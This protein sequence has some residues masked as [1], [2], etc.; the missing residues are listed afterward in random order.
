MGSRSQSSE[1][2][3]DDSP[4]SYDIPSPELSEASSQLQ[5]CI[6]SR[7]LENVD[8]ILSPYRDPQ[9]PSQLTSDA[10]RHLS[11]SISAAME[12]E[13]FS[14]VRSLLDQGIQVDFRG[15]SLAVAHALATGSTSVLEMLLDHGWE[16]Q[17][18][19]LTVENPILRYRS[20]F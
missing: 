9:N 10:Q 19:F 1:A 6:R 16:I 3:E 17:S 8:A 15:V 11:P 4:P 18:V 14:L 5:E 12:T 20:M 13:L 7:I 2:N